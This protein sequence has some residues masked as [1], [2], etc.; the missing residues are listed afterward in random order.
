[1]DKTSLSSIPQLTGKENYWEWALA[2]KGVAFWGSFWPH[3]QLPNLMAKSETP[4]DDEAE[5]GKLEMKAQGALFMSVSMVI[6]LDLDSLKNPKPEEPINAYIMWEHL[7]GKYET[8]D[9]ISAL[10]DFK[11]L[12]HASLTD[13]GT[14]EDQLNRC[15]T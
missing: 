15:R 9:G 3:Y 2:I 5:L 13:D 6:K 11:K 10:L 1:M 8:R 12:L 14:H 4:A 7:K